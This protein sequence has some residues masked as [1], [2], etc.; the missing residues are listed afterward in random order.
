MNS[1]HGTGVALIYAVSQWFFGRFK[2]VWE[3][4][5]EHNIN[6][7]V[8]YLGSVLGTTPKRPL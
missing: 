4:V 8:D 6:G 3:R 1:L 2:F 7:G 5:V